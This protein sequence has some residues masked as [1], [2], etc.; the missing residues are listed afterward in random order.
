MIEIYIG[1]NQKY[2]IILYNFNKYSDINSAYRINMIFKIL[3]KRGFWWNVLAVFQC[4]SEL[5]SESELFSDYAAII[6]S[7]WTWGS[8]LS[9]SFQRSGL[10]RKLD[11]SLMFIQNVSC[12]T[13][14]HCFLNMPNIGFMLER[15]M[16]HFIFL[17]K[18][19]SMIAKGKKNLFVVNIQYLYV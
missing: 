1:M 4:E 14:F 8:S 18:K 11:V 19:K 15:E 5:S 12:L 17:Y 9:L 10:F 2:L 7:S 16:W 3:D 13:K 6:F